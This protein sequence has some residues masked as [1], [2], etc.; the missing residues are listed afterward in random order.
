MTALDGGHD[1][2]VDR[3]R[4]A[5]LHLGLGED[6]ATEHLAGRLGLVVTVGRWDIGLDVHDRL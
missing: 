5:F 3:L 4:Q 2:L 1:G 6:V